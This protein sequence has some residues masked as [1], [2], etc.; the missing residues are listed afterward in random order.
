MVAASVFCS[1]KAQ[2][3]DSEEP[4]QPIEMLLEHN[5]A[6]AQYVLRKYAQLIIFECDLLVFF[7]STG[8]LQWWHKRRAAV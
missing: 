6:L 4:S 3:P 2:R 8:S 1:E 5:K 7:K